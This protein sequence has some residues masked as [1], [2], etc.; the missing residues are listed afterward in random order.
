MSVPAPSSGRKRDTWY[1]YLRGL[2]PSDS[3]NL[4]LFSQEALPKLER[5]LSMCARAEIKSS[6]MGFHASGS[7]NLRYHFHSR[8]SST[9][10]RTEAL[11]VFLV[12]QRNEHKTH[13][14]K[15]Y[16]PGIRTLDTYLL[17]M[18]AVY[19]TTKFL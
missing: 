1:I 14:F 4:P 3:H 9:E 15:P 11:H 2:R 10:T 6:S 5:H 13:E 16:V 7:R 19:E 17:R 8:I 18:S 12:R